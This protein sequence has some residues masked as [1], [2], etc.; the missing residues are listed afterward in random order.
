MRYEM[1]V[2][3]EADPGTV[4]EALVDVERWPEWTA[5]MREVR[6]LDSGDMALGSRA[7]IRQPRMPVLVWEVTGFEPGREFTWTSHSAGV[8][9]VGVHRVAANP[10]GTATALLAV[11]QTGVLAP[12]VNLFTGA[13]TRRYLELE[14]DGLKRRSEGD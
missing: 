7:R 4:W 3:I 1:S 11:D 14:T 8:T 2:D 6:R 9:T 5:S 10:D 13:Q 12:L